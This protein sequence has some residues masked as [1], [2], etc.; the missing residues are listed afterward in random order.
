MMKAKSVMI[1]V[2][3]IAIAVSSVIIKA[4]SDGASATDET[5]K[6]NQ[7]VFSA[8]ENGDIGQVKQPVEKGTSV[9]GQTNE[10][11]QELFNAARS[12]DIDQ[13]KQLVEKGADV[14][15]SSTNFGPTV[16]IVAIMR[17]HLDIVKFLVENGADVN[18]GD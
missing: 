15:F 7:K 8:A 18:V 14:N 6:S 12:G 17:G 16:L 2:A 9:S 11:N 5:S 1:S 10:L 13:V 3:I 4:V